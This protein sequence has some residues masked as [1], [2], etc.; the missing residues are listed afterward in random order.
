MLC[1]EPCG[2]CRVDAPRIT[3]EELLVLKREVPAWSIVQVVQ[4]EYEAA[5]PQAGKR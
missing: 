5:V 4:S 2:A 1:Q 3:S